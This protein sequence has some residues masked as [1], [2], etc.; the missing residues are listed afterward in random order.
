MNKNKLTKYRFTLV[1]LI[2]TITILGMIILI[3]TPK[4]NERKIAN[5][6]KSFIINARNIIREI[7]YDNLDSE[8]FSKK[9]LRE[10]D[11]ST[12]IEDNFDVN[13]SYVYIVDDEVVLNLVGKN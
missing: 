5:T 1:E 3:A 7:E 8:K 2:A 9:S 6:K 10:F 11:F 13:N 12:K 4:I